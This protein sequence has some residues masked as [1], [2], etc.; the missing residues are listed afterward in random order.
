MKSSVQYSK[1]HSAEESAQILAALTERLHQASI[2]EYGEYELDPSQTGFSA[3]H[4]NKMTMFNFS[5]G[6]TL[7]QQPYG[8]RSG[9]N[10]R[11]DST[12]LS[13]GITKGLAHEMQSEAEHQLRH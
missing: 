1:R 5:S 10:W 4:M 11:V 2:D 13:K 6:H 9:A 3:S 7:E 12:D 8:L